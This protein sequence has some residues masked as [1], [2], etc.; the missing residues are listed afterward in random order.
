MTIIVVDLSRFHSKID[1]VRGTRDSRV[2]VHAGPRQTQ[3]PWPTSLALVD[4]YAILSCI[5]FR[6]YFLR[7]GDV[8][9]QN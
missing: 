4:G 5:S 6:D 8:V 3:N 1:L 7:T 2:Y 9:K